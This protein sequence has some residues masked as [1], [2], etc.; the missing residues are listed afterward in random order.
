[1]VAASLQQVK[2]ELAARAQNAD[3]NL[4]C[5][6]EVPANPQVPALGVRGPIR[7]TYGTDYDGDWSVTMAVDLF[8]N[9]QDLMRAQQALDAYISP[10]GNKSVPR[11]LED[12]TVTPGII[13]SVNVRGGSQPYAFY[14]DENRPRLLVA[15]IEVDVIPAIG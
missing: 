4:H 1:M 5:Y 11:V 7:W 9:P 12:T 6:A 15:T 8:A 2:A 13:Q 14:G 10:A 3:A